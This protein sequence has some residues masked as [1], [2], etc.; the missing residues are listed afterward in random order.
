MD[1]P[2][3]SPDATVD[4]ESD[5]YNFLSMPRIHTFVALLL[6]IGTMGLYMPYWAI[7]RAQ[8]FNAI[9]PRGQINMYFTYTVSLIYVLSSAIDVADFASSFTANPLKLATTYEL[10]YLILALSASI[11]FLVWVFHFRSKMNNF[12]IR[13]LHN[14]FSTSGVLLTFLLGVIYLNFKINQTLNDL[15]EVPAATQS[16][17]DRINTST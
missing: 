16:E 17:P 9:Y 8:R 14:T 1:D 12:L 3:R 11:G 5:Q 6:F 15:Q 2:Y 10:L 7:T 4:N 13:E